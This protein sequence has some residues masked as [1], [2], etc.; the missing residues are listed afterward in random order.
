MNTSE[1]KSDDLSIVKAMKKK[2][3]LEKKKMGY[4]ISSI[5]NLVIKVAMHILVGKVM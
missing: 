5:N 4:T 3:V 1:G 2:F